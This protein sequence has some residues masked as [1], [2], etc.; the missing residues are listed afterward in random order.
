MTRMSCS[1]LIALAPHV[2]LAEPP[3]VVDVDL[4]TRGGAYT[5]HVTLAHPD[6]GWDH[7]ADG[8]EM[9]DEAGKSL[10]LRILHHPHVKEQPF[11]RALSGVEIPDGTRGVFIVPRCSVDGWAETATRVDVP[12]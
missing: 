6:T 9:R 2:A 10:G 7:Y 8:W 11:T 1:L 3:T 5:V 12:R 4:Q